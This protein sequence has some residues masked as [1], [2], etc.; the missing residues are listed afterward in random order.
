MLSTDEDLS[1]MYI[2]HK[3]KR[4]VLLWCYGDVGEQSTASCKRTQAA[5]DC[6]II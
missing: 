5:G 6:F 1:E 2:L 3:R 4:D